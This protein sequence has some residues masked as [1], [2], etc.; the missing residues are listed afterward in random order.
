MAVDLALLDVEAAPQGG[1]REDV[2]GQ[3]QALP[4]DP[5]LVTLTVQQVSIVRSRRWRWRAAVSGMCAR[6]F[7][8]LLVQPNLPRSLA[9]ITHIAM[10]AMKAHPRNSPRGRRWLLDDTLAAAASMTRTFSS[11]CPRLREVQ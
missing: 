3:D 8:L 2:A 6:R 5:H 9:S 11:G 10:T 4:T 7:L 1:L